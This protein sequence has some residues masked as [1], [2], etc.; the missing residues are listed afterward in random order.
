MYRIRKGAVEWDAPAASDTRLENEHVL[1]ELDA[2]TGRI[3]KLVLKST[4][5]DLAAPDA[6][7]AVVVN[8]RSDTWGHAVVAYDDEAGE[9]ECEAV[10]L[11]ENGPVRSIVRVES[12]YG[13]STL[14]EDYILAR[15]RAVRR[16]ARDDRLARAARAAEA[17]L[18]DV[19]GH[20]DG[21]VRDAVRLTSS[22]APAATRSRAQSWV[23]VSGAGR[24]LTVANDAKYGYDV[25]GG[26]I[27]IS[28][29]RSPVW[30][31]HDPRELEDEGDY[32]YMD[33]G[34][35]TFDVR[36]DPARGRL[37]RRRRRAARDRAQPAARSAL[38]ETFHE[39][40]LPQ[41]GSFGDDGGGDVVV[42][43]VKGA[44]DGDGFVVRAYE[45]AGRA[46]A[47]RLEILGR[48]IEAD[49]GANEIKT[50]VVPQRRRGAGDRPARVVTG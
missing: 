15:G 37:A 43:A 8:D 3:A 7:H 45:S 10:R 22:G 18:P 34:R 50:F 48:E 49:F 17:A 4:G 23:D 25:R 36:L 26:D 33:Q 42:T 6:K 5:V 24:G 44:E 35:Q 28:A 11:L 39:G 21:D 1:L 32:V 40:P 9:F 16:R 13:D 14:R 46:G 31:W 29:V 41:R 27:G 2:S 12:R 20:G 19:R 30:A 38:I 47:R